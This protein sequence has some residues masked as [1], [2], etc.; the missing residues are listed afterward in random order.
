MKWAKRRGLL[1]NVAVALEASDAPEARAA[2]EQAVAGDPAPL[3]REHAL[4]A[5]ERMRARKSES[6]HASGATG[7]I[8]PLAKCR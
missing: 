4:W 3:V 6:T 7:D 2:L 1:R 8:I 5:L